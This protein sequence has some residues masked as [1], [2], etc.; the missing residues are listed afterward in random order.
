MQIIDAVK[1]DDFEKQLIGD[2]SKLSLII[3]LSL[4]MFF[5][6]TLRLI[7]HSFVVYQPKII[8]CMLHSSIKIFSRQNF[9]IQY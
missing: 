3:N 8:F 6:F 9:A 4:L 7:R 5:L 2:L 1:S